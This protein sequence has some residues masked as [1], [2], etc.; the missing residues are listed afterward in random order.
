MGNPDLVIII[1]RVVFFMDGTAY[2][3]RNEA[4]KKSI[5]MWQNHM[6]NLRATADK[7]EELCFDIEQIKIYEYFEK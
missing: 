6:E 4:I 7:P 3:N 1:N 2:E 5:D